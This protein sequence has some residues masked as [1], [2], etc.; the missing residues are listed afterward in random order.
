MKGFLLPAI[1]PFPVTS[2]TQKPWERAI[3]DARVAGVTFSLCSCHD[4]STVFREKL[5]VL[6][7]ELSRSSLCN[8]RETLQLI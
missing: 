3:D 6:T 1:S 5:S 8:L 7:V 2:V 4:N